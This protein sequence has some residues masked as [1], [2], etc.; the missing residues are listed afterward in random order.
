M[1]R[2]IGFLM[3]VGLMMGVGCGS[4]DDNPVSSNRDL[5][6]GTWLYPEVD[7]LTWSL[8]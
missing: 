5:L 6:V 2:M 7:A 1:K 4:D 3:V 8:T